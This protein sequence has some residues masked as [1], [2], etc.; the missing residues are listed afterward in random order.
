MANRTVEDYLNL[1][2]TIQVTHDVGADYDVWFGKVVEL[3]GCITETDT[4]EEL[5]PMILDAM[6]GWIETALEDG[7]TVPKPR[8]AEDYSGKFIARVPRSLHRELVQAAEREGVSLNA[9]LNVVL[10]R[11]LLAPG[12]KLPEED[13]RGGPAPAWPRLS[14][15]AWQ[16]M[17]A[18]G[19]GMEAHAIDEELFANWLGNQLDQVQSAIEGGY[20]PNALDQVDQMCAILNQV[21]GASPLMALFSRTLAALREQIDENVRYRE[22]LLRTMTRDDIRRQVYERANSALQ[23]TTVTRTEELLFQMA[24]RGQH[25]R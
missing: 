6:R 25:G 7:Q 20:V 12:S 19:L 21:S 11:G 8:P 23:T 17:S 10:T 24:S 9:F 13:V 3:P 14:E 1:P 16:T 2:Y 4:L 5:G 18:A 15:A 22:G